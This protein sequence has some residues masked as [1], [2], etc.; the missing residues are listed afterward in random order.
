M[1][2]RLPAAA[3]L[4]GPYRSAK[5]DDDVEVIEGEV[6]GLIVWPNFADQVSLL[7]QQPG[8]KEPTPGQ[9][10]FN[11]KNT[12]TIDGAKVGRLDVICWLSGFGSG[13]KEYPH[14]KVTVHGLSKYV[15]TVEADFTTAKE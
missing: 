2:V 9:L 10:Y 6:V 13:R 15:P 12:V 5:E 11:G 1:K 7:V 14:V 8:G 3:K 4:V